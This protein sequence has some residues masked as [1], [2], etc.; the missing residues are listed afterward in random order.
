MHIGTPVRDIVQ[1]LHAQKFSQGM[2]VAV[3][4]WP[5]MKRIEKSR[6]QNFTLRTRNA[7]SMVS[8]E[9]SYGQRTR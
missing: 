5:V 8:N 9:N 7:C 6:T 2:F 3:A 4:V 1:V